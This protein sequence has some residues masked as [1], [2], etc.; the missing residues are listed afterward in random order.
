[1]AGKKLIQNP[2]LRGKQVICEHCEK[3]KIL[4][5]KVRFLCSDIVVLVLF[6][7][8]EITKKKNKRSK[9]G[10]HVKISLYQKM[11]MFYNFH[12]EKKKKGQETKYLLISDN[13]LH[14]ILYA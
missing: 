13:C 3:E 9:C 6:F 5:G 7:F 2:L 10:H 12:T 8:K 14:Y 4:N 1:M 11:A